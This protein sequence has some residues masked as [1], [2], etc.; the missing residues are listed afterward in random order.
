MPTM[1]TIL[2]VIAI[3]ISIFAL[4]YARRSTRLAQTAKLDLLGEPGFVREVRDVVLLSLTMRN[5]GPVT[6]TDIKLIVHM[7]GNGPVS[8]NPILSL[9][10]LHHEAVTARLTRSFSAIDGFVVCDVVYEDGN[11]PQKLK[12]WLEVNGPWESEWVKGIRDAE[13]R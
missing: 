12:Y 2:A 5:K 6:A 9:Q 11:G 10:P 3:I 7:P 13:P 1:S 4:V 8:S